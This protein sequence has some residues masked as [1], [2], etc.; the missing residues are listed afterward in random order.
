M[1]R[2]RAGTGGGDRVPGAMQRAALGGV[3]LREPGP[4]QP[5]ASVTFPALRSAL[6]DMPHR[7]RDTK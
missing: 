5:P 7:V 6:E 2:S 4:H 3:M 1:A